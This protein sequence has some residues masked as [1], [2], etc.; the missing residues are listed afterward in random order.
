MKKEVSPPFFSLLRSHKTRISATFWG[1]SEERLG[2]GG[3]GG[4]EEI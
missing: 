2:G 1:E 4:K 3:G